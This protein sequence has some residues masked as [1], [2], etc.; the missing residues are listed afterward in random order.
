VM[1]IIY[2][3]EDMRLTQPVNKYQQ[4]DRENYCPGVAVGG[5]INSPMNPVTWSSR[6]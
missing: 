3:D 6:S 5:I 4:A 1:T 2:M